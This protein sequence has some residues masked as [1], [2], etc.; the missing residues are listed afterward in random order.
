M[1]HNIEF[2]WFTELICSL[3]EA[4]ARKVITVA[5]ETG[6]PIGPNMFV[7]MEVFFCD[8]LRIDIPEFFEGIKE[9]SLGMEE[10]SCV[11]TMSIII[12][13]AEN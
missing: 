10:K 2:K 3:E 5:W 12:M 6:M 7:A 1:A 13:I 9:E 8:V 11:V 4:A